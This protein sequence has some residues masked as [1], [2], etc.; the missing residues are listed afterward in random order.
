MNLFENQ[1]DQPRYPN[2]SSNPFPN[3]FPVNPVDAASQLPLSTNGPQWE[4]RP[5]VPQFET[6]SNGGFTAGASAGYQPAL[7]MNNPTPPSGGCGNNVQFS[8]RSDSKPVPEPKVY[9][10]Q[11]G[12]N[13]KQEWC[14]NTYLNDTLY[15]SDPLAE[16]FLIHRIYNVVDLETNEI[17]YVLIQYSDQ[18]GEDVAVLSADEFRKG[19]YQQAMKRIRKAVGCTI[20]QLDSLIEFLLNQAPTEEL[21]IYQHPGLYV[22]DGIWRFISYSDLQPLPSC[23]C[24]ESIRNRRI[25]PVPAAGI[26]LHEWQRLFG[27]NPLLAIIAL[28]TVGSVLLGLFELIGIDLPFL[29]T[30]RP[31]ECVTADQLSAMLRLS[32]CPIPDLDCSDE[33]LLNYLQ[34]HWDSPAPFHDTSFADEARKIESNL[35]L[36]L[37]ELRK[38]DHS[39]RNG[40]NVVVVISDYA[41]AIANSI[42]A[43]NVV[44]IS[45]NGAVL[46]ASPEE[47]RQVTK[48]MESVVISTVLSHQTETITFFKQEKQRID[49]LITSMNQ[50]STSF[51]GFLTFLSVTLKYLQEFLKIELLSFDQL[52]EMI[53]DIKLQSNRVMSTDQEIVQGFAGVISDRIRTGAFTAMQK[54]QQMQIDPNGNTVIV[55]GERIYLSREMINGILSQMTATHNHRGL[56]NALKNLKVLAVTDGDTH[57]IWVHDLQG[58]TQRLYWYDLPVDL[59]DADIVHQLH[60]LDS[61][62]YWLT[63]DEIPDQFI[64][65]LH[66]ESGRVAGK[67]MRQ[68]DAENGH[69]YLTGQSGIG[70]SHEN[71]QL[72]AKMR[73]HGHHVV[74]FD[75]NA[76]TTYEAMC[77]NLSKE[78]VDAN[79]VFIDIDAYGIPFDLFQIDRTASKPTQKKVLRGILTA[80]VGEL[81][82]PQRNRLNTALSEMLDLLAKNEPIRTGDILAMLNEE[83]TTYE[84]LRS[85][86]EPLFEDIDALGMAAGSWDALFRENEGKIIVIRTA[87]GSAEHG[88]Q[89]IDMMLASLFNYQKEIHG[90]PLDIFID[91]LQNQNL[92]TDS[93]IYQ[94]LKEGRKYGI[95]FFG[96]TQDFYPF[97]TELGK[98]MSKADTQIILRPTPNSSNAVAADL[99]FKKGDGVRFDLMQRGDAIIKGTFYDKEQHRNIPATLSGKLVPYFEVD[100]D[101][102]QSN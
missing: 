26:V 68:Q 8:R 99:R 3:G 12:F 88:N 74:S 57:P 70:K 11:Y 17:R 9:R 65:L 34:L 30:I 94:I 24:P 87:S 45:M 97:N 86:F 37:R 58:H 85:R 55:D 71:D 90:V 36:L 89:L 14:F 79:V 4:N 16:W 66:D 76:S 72:M 69:V 56:I 93:P 6:P 39:T 61:E 53:G 77:R 95:A 42:S 73:A 19:K 40:C 49:E 13:E 81:T 44:S 41:A 33:K 52:Q 54:R 32:D 50:Q 25:M 27:S 18:N 102:P 80:G 98:I 21:T 91:E 75:N 47:I 100:T 64:A 5:A 20:P 22:L 31:S 59:L 92:S 60:N 38:T 1:Y 78:Y 43:D 46:H 83:G 101:T 96:V 48:L 35:R 84:S 28:I 62:Q 7:A 10:K 51:N 67:L 63:P 29:L 23:I 82:A 2:A 15:K